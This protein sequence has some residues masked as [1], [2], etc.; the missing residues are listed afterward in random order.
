MRSFTGSLTFSTLSISTLRSWSPTFSTWKMCTVWMTSRVFWID[1]ERTARAF[2]AHALGGG[3]QR[4]A[5]GVAVRLLQRFVDEPR[6]V[7]AADR[8]DVWVTVELLIIGFDEFM[9]KRRVDVGIVVAH[10]D[11]AERDLAHALARAFESERILS[12]HLDLG[13]IDAA[14]GQRP[15]DRGR[16]GA[17]RDPD[18]DR[19]RIGVLGALHEGGEV[20]IGHRE[21][22]RADDLAAGLFEAGMEGAFGVDAGAVIGHHR[23]G[24]FHAL[25]GRPGA[26]RLVELRRGRRRAGD[27]GRLCRD[28][29]G[30][31]V[32]HQHELL[33]LGGNVGDRERVRRQRKA[34]ENVGV[35][36]HDQ[37]LRQPFGEIGRHAADILA[38][39]FELLAGHHV[40]VLLHI[41]LDAAV[42]LDAGVGELARIRIDDADLD[43]VLGQ[44]RAAG[45]GERRR[46]SRKA[47][48]KFLHRF[49]RRFCRAQDIR[50]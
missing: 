1:G 2:P 36:A 49:L 5:V 37:F 20:R 32:H 7:I 15:A 41:E 10:G 29:R 46:Q 48:Q 42:E 47:A 38:D 13:R 26:E 39:E 44:R 9:I 21:A 31:R 35:I 24:G 40:A 14:L 45:D 6:A 25:L 23:V 27:I 50:A 19:V 17:A 34:R 12:H 43:S 16:L 33:G 4:F 3:D 18:V 30:G 28:D 22:H 8:V 11:D